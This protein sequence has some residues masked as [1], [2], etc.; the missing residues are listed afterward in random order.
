MGTLSPRYVS[1]GLQRIA[2]L[3][4]QAPETTFTS[5]HHHVDLALLRE[6]Y[7][8]TRKDGAVGVDGQS[9]ATYAAN[10]EGNL[11][12][13][14]DRFKSGRYCAPPVRRV[15]IPK[16][17]GR[18]TRPIGIPTVEDKV[19][20]RAVT[21]VLQAIYEQDFLPCSYG[22][23]PNRSAHDALHDL[24][25]GV[26][27][28]GG[29]W[30]IELDI[31][32]FFDTLNRSHLR[33]FLGRR[34]RD[35][36]LRRTI[37]KWLKAGVLEEGMITHPETGTPQGGVISPLLAN[38]YLH[39]VM[40]RWFVEQVTPR[41]QNQALLV[42]YADDAIL[43]FKEERDAR[44][45]LEVLPKRFARF[46]LRLHPGKT[47]LV[48]FLR[49]NLWEARRLPAA[50]GGP[51]SFDLLGFTH[52]WGRARS[53]GWVLK[54]Q[55]ARDRL[56]RAIRR[57]AEWCRDNRHQPIAWQHQQLVRKMRG[58]YSYYGITSNSRQLNAFRH[59]AHRLWHKWLNRRSQRQSLPWERFRRVLQRYPLPPVVIVHSVYHHAA[60]P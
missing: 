19:L 32:Q 22:F 41:L 26:M 16:G 30:V 58:H 7:R 40:D 43:V 56:R 21:M 39:E 27:R 51:G 47:R 38:V 18:K 35:G 14:L 23:R 8:L 36:I 44:K 60:N 31:E 10:L 17:D 25:E 15:H 4:R 42:R 24:R 59:N 45:V 9:A 13:L 48:K 37:D 55:T 34:V 5:I 53:G 28:M 29:G 54:R 46:G 50:C 49:P 2:E 1:T 11:R 33:E 12:A 3:A 52:Y 20:Q 57:V 6:A